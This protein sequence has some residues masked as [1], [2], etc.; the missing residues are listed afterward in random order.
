VL[1]AAAVFAM[2]GIE[3]GAH[4]S[5]THSG[6]QQVVRMTSPRRFYFQ[7]KA[8]N[9]LECITATSLT[10]AKL[11]AADT[12]LEWWSQIEWINAEPTHHG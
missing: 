12:W 7:I 6:T 10:E 9:V 8:A 11:I 3:S 1:I 2:I 5:P 4:H